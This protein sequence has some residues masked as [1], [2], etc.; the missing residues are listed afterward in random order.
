MK[1][2]K[3]G[4]GQSQVK[5]SSNLG[6]LVLHPRHHQFTAELGEEACGGGGGER[7]KW[8]IKCAP[9]PAEEPPPP[10]PDSRRLLLV[11]GEQDVGGGQGGVPAQVHLDLGGEPAEEV[12]GQVAR[13]HQG[14]SRGSRRGGVGR[15]GRRGRGGGGG[16]GRRGG[17]DGDGDG[18]AAATGPHLPAE[19]GG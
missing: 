16:Q 18:R 3:G 12:A 13:N 11:L 2:G 6:L 9:L 5:S 19:K 8:L 4:G 1:Q 14:R 17:G 10:P 15:N 7:R